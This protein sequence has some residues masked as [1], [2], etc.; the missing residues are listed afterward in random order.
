M[1]FNI[2]LSKCF[3]FLS[4]SFSLFELLFSLFELLHS[5]AEIMRNSWSYDDIH[6]VAGI[7]EYPQV[8]GGRATCSVSQLTK[9]FLDIKCE[10]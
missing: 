2:K 10:T 9:T 7:R 6:R 3:F 1:D 8:V 5:C 4:L